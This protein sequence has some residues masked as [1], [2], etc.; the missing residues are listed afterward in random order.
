M[1]K[2][3]I[4]L[5]LLPVLLSGCSNGIKLKFV[6]YS[7]YVGKDLMVS[8]ETSYYKREKETSPVTY[9]NGTVNCLSDMLAD[10]KSAN[11][12]ESIPT[13]GDRN[14][15][16]IPISFKDSD[17]D[18]KRR[19]DGTIFLKNAFFGDN[20]RTNYYSVAGYYN[21]SSYGQ[22]RLNGEVAPWFDLDMT[23]GDLLKL[24][25]MTASST[26]VAK[27]VDYLKEHSDIDFSAYDTDGDDHIDGVYAIYD[28]P[29]NE[30]SKLFWAYTHYTFEGE[31][32]LNN[33]K[34]FLNGYSWTSLETII[35]KDNR[36]Y[37]NYLIHETG[38]L[39][40]LTDYYN[41]RFSLDDEDYKFQPT[42]CFDMMD[43]NIGDHS[44]FSKYLFKWTSPMVL[45]K[46]IETTIKLKPFTTS[47]EYIL[48]P[49]SKYN[50]T[51]FSEYLLLEY[52]APT[53][54]NK[55]SGAYS[56]TD[57]NGKTGIYKYPQYYGLKIYH[58]NATLGYFQ[59]TMNAQLICT[60]DDPNWQTKIGEN[61]VGLDFAY[62][63]TIKNE[64][65]GSYPVLVHL[66][67]SSGKNTF[68]DA[69][70]ANNN[71]LFRIGDDFGY[72]KFTDFA[73]K[74]EEPLNFK[75]KVKDLSTRDITLEISY[76]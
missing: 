60:I 70:P 43:Y 17:K 53:G 68:K 62:S 45:K 19:E 8:E 32:S 6:P 48:I 34:P 25:Y 30:K 63:N 14:L 42:G 16:V 15:L 33:S 64:D 39:L 46:N 22:L 35:Q 1:K 11:F 24:P 41:T 29:V 10:Y 44:S 18:A 54:A 58:V 71:T 3:Y 36:S 5:F 12:R 40:G 56:Y 74:D 65:V 69:I 72:T 4:S 2:K 20:S 50:N 66:L 21:S 57:A 76:K 23:S 52:F 9:K 37:T 59:S 13:T 26:A 75:M 73:F 31:N 28:Y 67:E 47:G 51:P 7:S 38:H 27:A 49:S 61:R 55:F